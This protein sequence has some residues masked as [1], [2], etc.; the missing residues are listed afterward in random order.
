MKKALSLVLAVLMVLGMT[1]SAFAANYLVID[2]ATGATKTF[3]G[4]ANPG[5]K[6][7]Y[8]L[9]TSQGGLDVAATLS[10]KVISI[11]ADKSTPA[12]AT[13]TFSGISGAD[14]QTIIGTAVGTW[15][16]RVLT[17][18][19]TDTAQEQALSEKLDALIVKIAANDGKVYDV[20]ND[21]DYAV[22]EFGLT[23]V[24]GAVPATKT[25]A[26]Y[27]YY[28]NVKAN[29]YTIQV[30]VAEGSG[31]IKTTNPTIKYLSKANNDAPK[32]AAYIEL[33]FINPWVSTSSKDFDYNIILRADKSEVDTLDRIVGTFRNTAQDVVDG[34]DYVFFP[35]GRVVTA[36]DSVRKLTAELDYGIEITARMLED[37]RYYGW[38]D[39]NVSSADEDVIAQYP[40]I[41]IVYNLKTIG[42][43]FAGDVVKFT[44][45]DGMFAYAQDADGGLV[46]L[47]ST[48]KALPYQTKYFLSTTELDLPTAT[49]EPAEDVVPE[50]EVGGEVDNSGTG[51]DDVIVANNNDNP[52]TGC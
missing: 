43:N 46:Y 23:F 11:V 8:Y 4:T 7:R 27:I 24:K 26:S 29:K 49:E 44:H 39:M 12:A 17:L 36:Q 47:G 31:L 45:D 13:Y 34:D 35:D 10:E 14:I 3:D 21:N 28:D 2:Y 18:D 30:K 52:G 50:P 6:I 20:A 32:G 5:D 16:G 9:V 22:V 40:T 37:K 38:A 51:G 25:G 15:S 19:S 48:N 41:E 42:L 1:T 33:E